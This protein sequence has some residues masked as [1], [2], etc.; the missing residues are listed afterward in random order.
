MADNHT[1]ETS[2]REH[3]EKYFAA[4]QPDLPPKGLHE[5]IMPLVERPLIRAALEATN[6]HRI[7]AAELLGINRNT[8]R[9]RMAELGIV[10]K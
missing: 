1:L 3:I 8:L 9:K 10:W 2:A 7:Q 4:H 6:G 5:K